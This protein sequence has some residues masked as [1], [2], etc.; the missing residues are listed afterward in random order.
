M[1][2]VGIWLDISPPIFRVVSVFGALVIPVLW[3]VIKPSS[4]AQT[5]G[6]AGEAAVDSASGARFGAR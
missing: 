3:L 1:E 6:N 2:R 5:P 4:H